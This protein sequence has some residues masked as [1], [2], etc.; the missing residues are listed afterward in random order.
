[1]SFSV[2]L[3]GVRGSLPRPHTPLEIEQKLQ[4]VIADFIEAGHSSVDDIPQFIRDYPTHRGSGYGGNTTCVEVFK[5][6][7]SILIDG[8]SAIRKKAM[9]LMDGPCAHG[10]GEVHILMTHFHWDHLM[11]FPFFVP[12]FIPGN[13]IHLYAVQPELPQL[14]KELFRKPYFPVPYEEL[15]ANFHFHEL[16]PRK[17]F[18]LQGFDV[19]PYQL[20]H[21]DPCWGYR[22]ERDELAYSHCVDTEARRVTPEQMGEDLPLYQNV[23]C[24]VF[25]AQY[26][27]KEATEKINWG[28]G[29]AIFGIDLAIRENIKNI[30]FVHHDPASSDQKI[31][32]VENEVTEY[33]QKMIRQIDKEGG[34]ENNIE[35]SFAIE[36][37][38][39][40]V[41]A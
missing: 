14:F 22:I 15:G 36:D 9:E 2:K 12:L 3:W 4:Q 38:V 8:G 20:D 41:G 25:D 28:H 37:Q 29:A 7:Q 19:T 39:I 26:T 31:K 17:T 5:G 23:D 24:M 30:L 34:L 21:P 35:W 10:K 1:M 32:Q 27:V 16:K 6:D 40:E 18:E 33:C 11:G 13:Q